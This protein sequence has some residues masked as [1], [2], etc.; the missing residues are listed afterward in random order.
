M[1]GKFSKAVL[2]AVFFF[3]FTIPGQA[4]KPEHDVYVNA[5]SGYQL[6]YPAGWILDTSSAETGYVALFDQRALSTQ[7][8]S[9]DLLIGIKIEILTDL[10]QENIAQLID[11][12]SVSTEIQFQETKR[13]DSQ[14]WCYFDETLMIIV[15]LVQE[16]GNAV[17][18]A[19]IPEEN[20]KTAYW[21]LYNQIL[22]S[23]QQ[24]KASP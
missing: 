14:Y 22:I 24:Y 9:L 16:T 12:C 8:I 15:P 19:Y 4:T 20:K 6:S 7:G 23:F 13:Q 1:R 21:Q 5:F 2:F 11:G 3:L 17:L 10:T 18:I